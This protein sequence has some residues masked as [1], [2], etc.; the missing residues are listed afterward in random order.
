[1]A[2]SLSPGTSYPILHGLEQ[3]GDVERGD[4]LLG[5]KVRKY[6]TVITA[7]R[8]GLGEVRDKIRELT[9]EVLGEERPS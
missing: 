9:D 4:R 7:G 2:T 5:G 3:S 8:E 6:Y 1:M